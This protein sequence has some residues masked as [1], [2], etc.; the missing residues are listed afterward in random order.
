MLIG[1]AIVRVLVAGI[2]V[3]ATPAAALAHAEL[4]SSNPVADAVLTTAPHE[5]TLTFSDELD[6]GLSAFVV[7]DADGAEVGTG[8]VDLDVAERNVL[9]GSMSV[10]AHGTYEVRWSVTGTDGHEVTGSLAFVVGDGEV[11]NTASGTRPLAPALVAGVA[12]VVL[13]L[14]VA[15]RR[16]VPS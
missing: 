16:A 15:A 4:T 1:R 9:R 6:D 11:P 13:S 14:V 2:L 5:I 12:L 3:I 8:S 7:T 10:E